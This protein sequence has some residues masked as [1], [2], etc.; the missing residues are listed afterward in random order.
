METIRIRNS[1]HDKND[2]SLWSWS[3]NCIRTRIRKPTSF[4][5][6]MNASHNKYYAQLIMR[7]R[8][9]LFTLCCSDVLL[10]PAAVVVIQ[11]TNKK[12]GSKA[13]NLK[14]YKIWQKKIIKTCAFTL[15]AWEISAMN[16]F[17]VSIT[18]TTSSSPS[19]LPP[20][21]EFVFLVDDMKKMCTSIYESQV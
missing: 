14:L 12:Q 6:H 16:E 4:C 10:L 13:C 7:L 19:A 21:C 8:S 3:F 1:F 5:P 9:R 18:L 11:R 2:W 20:N 17:I 15:H